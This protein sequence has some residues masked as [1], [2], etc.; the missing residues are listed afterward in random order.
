MSFHELLYDWAAWGWPKLLNHLW[1]STII[2]LVA[3]AFT[4]LFKRGPARLRYAVLLVASVKFLLPSALLVFIVGQTGVDFEAVTGPVRGGWQSAGIVQRVTEPVIEITEIGINGIEVTQTAQAA[5]HSELYCALTLIWVVGCAALLWAW[6]TR[7][8]RLAQKMRVGTEISQ[9]SLYDTLERARAKLK[10]ARPIKLLVSP[11]VIVPGVWRTRRPVIALPQNVASHLSEEEVEAM[12]M[13]EMVHVARWDNLASNL[14]MLLCCLFWFNPLIWLIDRR[15]LAEREAACDEKV[16]ELGASSTV[17]AASLLKVFRFSIGWKIAGL[18]SATGSDLERRVKNIMA[19]QTNKRLRAR[20]LL[21]GLVTMVLLALSTLTGIVGL[22]SAAALPGE[23]RPTNHALFEGR[24]ADLPS[25]TPTPKADT[26]LPAEAVA[27]MFENSEQAP[28]VPARYENPIDA[29]LI[30]TDARVKVVSSAQGDGHTEDDET[31]ELITEPRITLANNTDRRIIGLR[32]AF[33]MKPISQD[34]TKLRASIPPNSIRTVSIDRHNWS[35]ILVAGSAK[36]LVVKVF[37]VQFE[38]GGTWGTI[39]TEKDVKL[40]APRAPEALI[41]QPP[42]TESTAPT[43]EPEGAP[44]HADPLPDDESVE[45]IPARFVNPPGA[46]IM[47]TEA[48]TRLG[49]RPE[50]SHS[51]LR[52]AGTDEITYLPV[53]TLANT[54]GKRIT[55][56][57][58]RFKADRESHAVTFISGPIAPNSIYTVRKNTIISGSAR[59][60]RVQ[61]LGV[62]FEDGSVWGSLD[63]TINGR[64]EFVSIPLSISRPGPEHNS[65]PTPRPPRR[66]GQR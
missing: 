32:L 35:N 18:S 39:G 38:D 11:Q 29:P 24:N 21:I 60:M 44:S 47:I 17:Y 23:T 33:Y 27:R 1:Q 57:K 59:N 37:S 8:A 65:Q 54:T 52:F 5:R 30:I 61:V 10:I 22:N 40:D 42:V 62:K 31:Y 58:L 46:P 45:Y 66:D 51:A 19:G 34:I 16:I 36:R 13:H 49:V 48:R 50:D 64:D 14:N 26:R 53:L 56:V 9:G 7:R 4:S 3:L 6:L 25:Q 43:P 2:L 20:R 12:L 28:H 15:L 41:E 63:S 55:G